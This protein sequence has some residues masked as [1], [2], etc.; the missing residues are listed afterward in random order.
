M[1]VGIDAQGA[2]MGNPTAMN[3]VRVS[4]GP[5]WSARYARRLWLSD[6]VA[7][8]LA[9][10]V[11][12]VVRFD[13]D[14]LPRVSGR[15]SPS[16]LTVS[17]VLMASWLAMLAGGHS[18]DRRLVGSGPE[19]YA[20]VFGLT[21]RL[22]AGVAVVAYL[23]QMQIGRGYIAIA[24]PLGLVLLL[25]ER[26]CWR[27]WLHGRRM[28][29]DYQS[30][31]LVIGHSGK[32]LRLI[33]TFHRNPR[34]GYGVIGVC[35]PGGEVD[36]VRTDGGVTIVG[37]IEEAAAVAR[38]I[39]ADAVAVAG[40]DAITADAV[41]RLGWDLEGTGIDLALAVAL[42][43]VAGPRVRMRPVNGLP[44]MYV[45]E[46]HFSGMKFVAKSVFDWLGALCVTFLLSPVL[47]VVAVAV[48]IS[49]RGPVFYRQERVG[50]DG[51]HFRM[52]KFR[53][54]V[55]G[56][57]ERLAEVLALEGVDGVGMFYKP[58]SDPRVTAVG[59]FIRKY[60]LDELPQLLNVLRGEMSLVGPRPQID[61]EVAQYD[62]NAHRRLLVKPGMTGLW[63]VSGRSDLSIEDGIRMDVYYVENWSLF[64]DILILARTAKVIVVGAGAY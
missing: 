19:E 11:A 41:R 37:S 28:D 64:G 17:L 33:E 52:F 36:V 21:W 43:D 56:A 3:R 20:R 48:K 59:R 6:A 55:S 49:S 40:S 16:Y 44:L 30:G 42:T 38:R 34:A 31:I 5:K 46:P 13:I 32:V 1:A 23:L 51:R 18:R 54:M 22:Y 29:G 24:A 14:G 47:G 2:V 58:K 25:L 35:V 9:V 62:R 60:S 15:F 50:R 53:S 39:G 45:D 57:H 4:T 10:S 7:V 63:Q 26:F 61:H 12:Y 27:Q 8:A